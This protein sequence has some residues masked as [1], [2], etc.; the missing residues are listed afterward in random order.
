MHPSLIKL[1]ALRY[2]IKDASFLYQDF[3]EESLSPPGRQISRTPPV[4]P[5]WSLN[6][7]HVHSF[8]R[9]SLISSIDCPFPFKKISGLLKVLR[10]ELHIL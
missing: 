7:P 9:P 1:A 6:P 5:D 3:V 8:L 4:P 10:S 2:Q